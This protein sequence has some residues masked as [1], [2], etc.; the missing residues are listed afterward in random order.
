MRFRSSSTGSIPEPHP[1]DQG[2]DPSMGV[3]AMLVP[4]NAIGRR[5]AL[6][7]VGG[8][9]AAALLSACGSSSDGSA[10]EGDSSTSSSGGSADGSPPSSGAGGSVALDAALFDESASCTLTPE[11]MEGPYWFDVDSVRRDIREDR[12]GVPLR[13]GI[14]VRAG[15]SCAPVVDAVVEIWHCDADGLYSGFEA[16]SLGAG[17]GSGGGGPGRRRSTPTDESTYL[18]GAQITDGDGIVELRTIYPG[19]YSG[20]TAHIHAK[21]HIDN[22]TVLTTQLYFP[23]ELND[24]VSGGAY[25][26]RGSPDTSNESDG[27]FDERTVVS[28]R[29]DGEEYLATITLDV[30]AG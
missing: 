30:E 17:G 5:A 21:V 27:I 26:G 4:M 16:A 11:Q 19:W 22:S 23:A 7:A 2:T 28:I 25:A 20:R 10:D 18:R 12:D 6:G 15:A 1:N 13:L 3:W 8:L 9:G 14:R 29:G 24:E